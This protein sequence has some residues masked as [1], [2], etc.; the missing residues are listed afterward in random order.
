MSAASN[1]QC[2]STVRVMCF[3]TVLPCLVWTFLSRC[4]MALSDNKLRYCIN[5]YEWTAP[6]S[7]HSIQR[8]RLLQ[9][10]NCLP[11]CKNHGS[12]DFLDFGVRALNSLNYKFTLK[13]VH[14]NKAGRKI[15]AAKKSTESCLSHMVR[16]VS[17]AVWVSAHFCGS[18]SCLTVQGWARDTGPRREP[19]PVIIITVHG[20][21]CTVCTAQCDSERSQTLHV[22]SA[23]FSCWA[24]WELRALCS[25]SS[26]R[27]ER[28]VCQRS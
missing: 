20:E 21:Y 13:A 7:F 4:Q 11:R 9:E 1:W 3:G 10:N 22:V 2:L 28:G 23:S 5:I 12:T 19:R 24:A 15:R 25:C 6:C 18:F 8:I 14:W 27:L 17:V 26:A 16:Y